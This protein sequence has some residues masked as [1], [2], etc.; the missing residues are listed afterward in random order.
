[1]YYKRKES[2]RFTFESPISGKITNQ[3]KLENYPIKI[4]DISAT[5]LKIQLEKSS[6]PLP[7]KNQLIWIEFQ[8]MNHPFRSTG[9]VVCIKDFVSHIIC[10]I[11]VT[12]DKEWEESI[13]TDL[14]LYAK[15]K[16]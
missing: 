7:K 4:M 13:I 3:E 16:N 12:T 10:E 2:F 11:K 5:G 6:F 9:T 8:L 15:I 1:M 14:K